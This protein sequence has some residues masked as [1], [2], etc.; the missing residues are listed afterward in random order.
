MIRSPHGSSSGAHF[1]EGSYGHTGF[2]GNS[3][4]VDP[5]R[6]LV[7]ALLTNAV[8]FGRDHMGTIAFRPI[9]HNAVIA[10]L[11]DA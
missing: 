9:F 11:E 1:N 3:L 6:Q 7:V 5:K 2:V 8:F 10:A 4:W